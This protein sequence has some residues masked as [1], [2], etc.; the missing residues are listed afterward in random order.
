LKL[1]KL[2]EKYKE[3]KQK[4]LVECGASN[5]DE[6]PKNLKKYSSVKYVWVTMMSMDG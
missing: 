1:E 3:V 4:Y 2:E 5:E 6:K